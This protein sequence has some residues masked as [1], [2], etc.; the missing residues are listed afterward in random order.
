MHKSRLL[1]LEWTHWLCW[2]LCRD[3]ISRESGATLLHAHTHAYITIQPKIDCVTHSW[4]I[5]TNNETCCTCWCPSVRQSIHWSVYSLVRLLTDAE[6]EVLVLDPVVLFGFIQKLS[7]TWQLFMWHLY[8]QSR[9]KNGT[10]CFIRR[11]DSQSVSSLGWIDACSLFGLWCW[12]RQRFLEAYVSS[13]KNLHVM[14][15]LINIVSLSK[16]T[17]KWVWTQKYC[18]HMWTLLLSALSTHKGIYRDT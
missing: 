9:W 12:W 6:T 16:R 3:T 14:R 4:V 8:V 11:S 2:P 15:A 17:I 1:Y 5:K 13:I 10:L 18:Q 7:R